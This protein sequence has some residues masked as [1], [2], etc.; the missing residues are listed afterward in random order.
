[1]R[2]ST[3]TRGG[4][5]SRGFT[6]IEVLIALVILAVA[7]AAAV[8]AAGL[9]TDGA[10]ETKERLLAL[11]VAQNRLAGYSAGLAFPGTGERSGDEAQFDLSFTWRETVSE[12]AN[13]FFRRVEIK[14]YGARRPDYAI[15]KLV[16]HVARKQ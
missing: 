7:L 12:T 11:W 6:L 16:S 15:A 4:G 13:P 3:S 8:R 5:R 10:L 14:V 2:D 9:A 1:V